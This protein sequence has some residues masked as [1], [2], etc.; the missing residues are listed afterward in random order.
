MSQSHVMQFTGQYDI[1]NINSCYVIYI[2]YKYPGKISISSRKVKFIRVIILGRTDQWKFRGCPPGPS[3]S[4]AE[5]EIESG[6]MAGTRVRAWHN[7]IYIYILLSTT[8]YYSPIIVITTETSYQV[9]INSI[10]EDRSD[11]QK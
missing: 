7:Y 3:F 6:T 10:T 9:E 2:N 11:W 5:L 1:L 4:E 8:E